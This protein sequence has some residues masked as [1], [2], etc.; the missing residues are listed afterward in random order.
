MNQVGDGRL[1]IPEFQRDFK[2]DPRDTVSLL[3]SIIK[4][5]PIGSLLTWVPGSVEFGRRPVYLAPPLENS[6]AVSLI[7]DGQQ[8]VTSLFLS[9]MYQNEG[10]WSPSAK[11][12]AKDPTYWLH[13]KNFLADPDEPENYVTYSRPLFRRKKYISSRILDPISRK[14]MNFDELNALDYGYVP[15][16]K[17]Y[18]SEAQQ[19]DFSKYGFDTTL[20]RALIKLWTAPLQLEGFPGSIMTG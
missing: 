4:G 16:Y 9:F 17:I 18:S 20:N 6:S 14:L 5:Y 10:E 1:G 3:A 19:I 8:R 12:Q 7:L 13:L 15:L 11:R 2:W